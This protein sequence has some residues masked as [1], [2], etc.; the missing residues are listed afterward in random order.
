MLLDGAAPDARVVLE[1]AP[2]GVERF[3]HRDLRILVVLV[4]DDDVG[5]RHL[6]EEVHHEVLALVLMAP[7]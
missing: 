1:L 3:A 4:V 2:R 5:A 7:G 6:D